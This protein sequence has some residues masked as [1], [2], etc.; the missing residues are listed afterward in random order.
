MD[1][2]GFSVWRKEEHG[3]N[4]DS[5]DHHANRNRIRTVMPKADRS[6]PSMRTEATGGIA[7]VGHDNEEDVKK[8]R[9][10][11]ACVALEY[12]IQADVA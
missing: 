2:V 8:H 11:G 5:S 6:R 12:L 4:A 9:A 7:K 10:K 3:G 1:D